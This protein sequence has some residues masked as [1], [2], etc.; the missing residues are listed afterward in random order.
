[1]LLLRDVRS[2]PDRVAAWRATGRSDRQPADLLRGGDVAVQQGGREISDRYVVKT[3][4]GL[5]LWQQRPAI[6]LQSQQI[7]NRILVFRAVE[8]AKCF[9]P[10]GI[11]MSYGSAIQGRRQIGRASCRERG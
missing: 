10:A 6:D 9:G 8:P 4:A 1:M 7:A 11:G 2:N 5:I 3:V